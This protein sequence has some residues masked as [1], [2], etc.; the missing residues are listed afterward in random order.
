VGGAQPPVR[1]RGRRRN[2][3]R[4]SGRDR[5]GA[6]LLA[7]EKPCVA[8][9][10]ARVAL[11]PPELR[12]HAVD[13]VL[14]EETLVDPQ[15]RGVRAR[16]SSLR[17][18]REDAGSAS[19][20]GDACESAGR[21]TAWSETRSKV[22]VHWSET[23]SKVVVHLHPLWSESL[24]EGSTPAPRAPRRARQAPTSPRP[25]TAPARAAAAPARGAPPARSPSAFV[26]CSQI[27]R[28]VCKMARRRLARLPPSAQ[29]LAAAAR[30][31]G[32]RGGCLRW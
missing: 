5:L 10:E 26:L 11:E 8:L 19:A 27:D 12:P 24:C 32:R 21:G 22:V 17:E 31:A 2:G 15:R 20:V 16:R 28:A 30:A 7:D 9:R 18:R 13:R 3:W 4:D 29:G 6:N 23:R 1:G 14:H 25:R